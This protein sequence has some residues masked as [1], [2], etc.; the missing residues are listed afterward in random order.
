MATR[1]ES[2]GTGSTAQEAADVVAEVGRE[3]SRRLTE[4]TVFLK[5]DM[6]GRIPEL[7]EAPDLTGLL[8]AS[9][10]SNLEAV[11]LMLRGQL[12]REHIAAP[13]GAREYA[14]RLAQRG[15]APTA[16]ARAYRLGHQRIMDWGLRLIPELVPSPEMTGEASWLMAEI[17]FG[18]IDEVSEQVLR[19]YQAERDRWLALRN[20]A[21]ADV[22][23]QL[24]SGTGVADLGAAE[25]TLDHRLGQHHLG[26]VI[27]TSEE[28]ADLSALE[29][30]V[31]A[32]ARAVGSRGRPLF[33]PADLTT[34]W[35]WFGLGTRTDRPD[36]DWSALESAVAD[37]P[38]PVQVA[39][40][41]PGR[42]IEGFRS[43]H[44]EALRVQG[45]ARLG[46]GAARVTSF[47]ESDVRAAAL[48]AVDPEETRRLVART[49]GPLGADTPALEALRQTLLLFVQ[50]Q[51]SY[52][53]T[54]E[55]LHLHKNTV[56][57]RVDKALALRGRPLED[58]RLDLELALIACQRLGVRS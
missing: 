34:G 24:L 14:R 5:A 7:Q 38:A 47:G 39:L 49:L 46:G 31:G 52:V 42:G 55:R 57:Y 36:V 43:S 23:E 15:I 25:R 21:Q 58:D 13:Q 32:L 56:K 28:A 11:S 35:V 12:D 20:A 17:A 19:E 27:W 6:E 45:V 44:L 48:L 22:I 3:L 26:A 9:V 50:T 29:H 37:A 2:I 10:E 40:G 4:L 30:V 51:G 1:Q 16:L 41:S 18:Y 8:S 53:A 54:G 33:W